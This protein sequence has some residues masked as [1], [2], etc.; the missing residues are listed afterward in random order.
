MSK[1]NKTKVIAIKG[2][3]C[4]SCE[5]L[6]E[7]ELLKVEGIY[8]ANVSEKNG[9]AEIFYQGEVQD[10]YIA[11][12][13]CGCGY[14]LGKDTKGWVSKNPRDYDD[15]IKAGIA[16]AVIYFIAKGLGFFNIAFGSSNDLASLPIVF[17]VGLTAGLSTCMALIGGLVLG[18]SV[19]FSEKHPY[20][21]PLQKFKPHIFFN[22]GRLF[23]FVIFG[24]LIGYFGSFLQLGPASTG[25]LTILVGIVMLLLGL[26]TIGIFPGLEQLKFTLP[27]ALYKLVGID[28]QKQSGYSNKGSFI[29]GGMTFFLPCGFTQAM[30]LYAIASGNPMTGALTMGVFA[31]G[32]APG[33]V[34][35]GG[36]TALI[37][38]AFA[39]PFFKFVGLTVIALS[40]FNISNGLNLTGLIL[41]AI[42]SP[43][44]V[45]AKS[46]T[47]SS[48]P[49]VTVQNGVQVVKMTQNYNG[50]SPNSFTIQ[51]GIPVKWVIT[52][53]DANTCAA[54]IVSAQLGVHKYLR[55]GEN[56]IEFSPS[57]VGTIR[58]S[59][60]M[61]MYTGSFTVVNGSGIIGTAVA[62]P[63]A[64][65]DPAIQGDT[66]G[67]SGGCGCGGTTKNNQPINALPAQPETVP[68]TS[69]TNTSV[70]LIKASYTVDKD[71]VPNN[72][73]VKVNQPVRFEVDAKE[74]GYGC[75]GSVALPG[76]A[77]EYYPLQ[78]G[79][80]AVFN[81]TPTKTGNY[82]I[83]CAMGVPRGIITV[84]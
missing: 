19:R 40:F 64:N 34:G 66:C 21:T 48:D 56:I 51:K 62:I 17:L 52:S 82:Q 37:K 84:N 59:C 10:D 26:Q 46:G 53:T 71:I 72:F 13:V 78:K 77:P 30:Q 8:K 28:T 57:D 39:K 38:G 31:L 20:A 43:G 55:L 63:T 35:I 44:T 54:S 6:I 24:G 22:L 42:G 32:T 23:F 7:Q 47:A 58:F 70:Q 29:L 16:L 27:K 81:F 83:T 73:S 65:A 68:S 76:L 49:N 25:L 75:M 45:S 80:K 11:S 36:L 3:H 74:D 4:R 15:L 9:S 61:G 18:V 69:N 5:I 12:A 1:L 67:S 50:Y 41:P 79:Q 14:S 2:M 60:S 33:L